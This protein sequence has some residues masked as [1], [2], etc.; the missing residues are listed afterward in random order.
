LFVQTCLISSPFLQ[1]NYGNAS[2]L[3]NHQLYKV[4]V[5]GIALEDS[6]MGQKI[7]FKILKFP[8][9]NLSP[10]PLNCHRLWYCSGCLGWEKKIVT[11]W[12][13][14][15]RASLD[16]PQK[17][18]A[19]AGHSAHHSTESL[20]SRLGLCCQDYDITACGNYRDSAGLLYA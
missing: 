5:Y 18:S 14:K 8:V 7:I 3:K 20:I 9:D 16:N 17:S 11:S 10:L 2:C 15:E 1:K 6:R 13:N 4:H 19:A 12:S